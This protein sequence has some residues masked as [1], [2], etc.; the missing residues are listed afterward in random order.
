MVPVLVIVPPERG[1]L[2]AIEV[3]VPPLPVAAIVTES[4]VASVVIVTPVPATR[5]KVSEAES[6]TTSVWPLTAIVTNE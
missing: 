1:A 4:P 6:A 2:V 5:V 3:T